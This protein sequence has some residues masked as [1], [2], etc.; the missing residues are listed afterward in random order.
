MILGIKYC[1][2]C[3]PHY[4]RVAAVRE[5]EHSLRDRNLQFETYQEGTEYD[6]CLLV[7]GC[8]RCSDMEK[9]LVGCGRLYVASAQEDFGS[10]QKDIIERM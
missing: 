10:I 9:K 7:K 5:L 6:I 2:G 3:N 4:N 1:G 8:T